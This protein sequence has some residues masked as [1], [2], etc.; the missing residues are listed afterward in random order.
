MARLNQ[1]SM[2]ARQPRGQ[3][4]DPRNDATRAAFA[5]GLVPYAPLCPDGTPALFTSRQR[6]QARKA[7]ER[8]QLAAR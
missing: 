5:D 3:R 7:R 6:A 2:P 8:G 4:P 1:F